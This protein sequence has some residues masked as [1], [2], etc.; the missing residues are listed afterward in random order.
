M[1][2]DKALAKFYLGQKSVYW[3]QF[4][5]FKCAPGCDLYFTPGACEA[6]GHVYERVC[7]RDREGHCMCVCVCVCM[8]VFV[9]GCV[10]VCVCVRV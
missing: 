10:C 2:V 7:E 1:K 9:C 3:P 4:I 8:C 6:S 5:R